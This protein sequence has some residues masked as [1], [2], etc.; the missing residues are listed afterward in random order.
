MRSRIWLLLSFVCLTA[1]TQGQD[2]TVAASSQMDEMAVR[3]LS[4]NFDAALNAKDIDAMMARYADGAV[5][6]NPNAA[7]NVGKDAIRAWYV[8]DWAANDLKVANE[9][10]DMHISGDVAAVRGTY[11]S[12]VTPRNGGAA[13]EDRGKWMAMFQKQ[14]DA[15]WKSLW[16]IWSSDLPPRGGP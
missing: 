14:S 11:A 15:S 12:T 16:E 5:R 4:V 2:S 8:D 3:E 6:M 10:S 13:Y 7:T 1:C 9:I